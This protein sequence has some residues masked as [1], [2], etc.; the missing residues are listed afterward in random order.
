MRKDQVTSSK[1]RNLESWILAGG[2]GKAARL[3]YDFYV[4]RA[5]RKRELFCP[6]WYW[7]ENP[8]A[9]L[10]VRRSRLYRLG[11][12][13]L[14][15]ISK[16]GRLATHPI[17]HYVRRGAA[18][19]RNPC[20]FFD[21]ARYL[22]AHPE[23]VQ[24]TINPLW[25]CI[26]SGGNASG[27]GRIALP[28]A[29]LSEVRRESF[30][31][32]GVTELHTVPDRET[33]AR[34][35]AVHLHLFYPEM[36]DGFI[37]KLR[38]I[39]GSFDLFVSVSS[40]S[41]RKTT[42]A[43]LAAAFPGLPTAVE[44]VPNRGRDLAPLI[45]RFGRRLL[46]YD[47]ICHIHSKKSPH[48]RRLSGWL[49]STLDS[50]LG[51]PERVAGIRELLSRDGKFVYP[52]PPADVTPDPATGWSCNYDEAER[53]LNRYT[54]LDIRQFPVVDFP[55]GS[56]FWARSEALKRLL[57]LPLSFDDFPEEP[58]PPDGTPA[59]GLERLLLI[60]ASDVPGRAYRL[61]AAR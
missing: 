21:T 49:G 16:F 38:N 13:R 53:L 52:A 32:L 27:F 37:G 22:A 54:D 42:A 36:L 4:I 26:R 30:A 2:G 51:S 12:K 34:R 35:T 57:E 8:D 3:L 31:R 24:T 5:L 40:D 1:T 23:I 43:R 10:P 33:A 41:V 46:E 9:F 18:E 45:I 55:H 29:Q 48:D 28:P 56:M 47:F 25:H 19:L 17:T 6:L 20:I 50:L 44:T 7:N 39:P 58:I 61:T 59:H 11:Q 15:V 14:P 60:L